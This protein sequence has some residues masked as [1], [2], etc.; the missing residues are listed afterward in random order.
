MFAEPLLRVLNWKRSL[1]R[2]RMSL[3]G[4]QKMSHRLELMKC[5]PRWFCRIILYIQGAA[6]RTKR[7]S[8]Q[9]LK[10]GERRQTLSSMAAK[11]NPPH[12]INV[13]RI[14]NEEMIGLFDVT[15]LKMFLSEPENLRKAHRCGIFNLKMKMN[16]H[17]KKIILHIITSCQQWPTSVLRVDTFWLLDLWAAAF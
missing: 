17:R 16:V 5:V 11:N 10:L 9:T 2:R 12:R 15:Q 1:R 8:S 14:N 7:R 3:R 13:L 4:S 6:A